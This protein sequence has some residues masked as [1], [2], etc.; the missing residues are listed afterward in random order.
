VEPLD[1]RAENCSCLR[2]AHRRPP[3]RLSHVPLVPA[4]T[5]IGVCHP[6]G[7]LWGSR[8]MDNGF[9]TSHSQ[10][11]HPNPS[12][13][14]EKSCP[15]K[16]QTGWHTATRWGGLAK[17]LRCQRWAH[18]E[19]KLDK[20]SLTYYARRRLRLTVMRQ[21][22]HGAEA[23]QTG[24]RNGRGSARPPVMPVPSVPRGGGWGGGKTS[25][26]IAP[27]VGKYINIFHRRVRLNE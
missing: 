9:E 11:V 1:S 15:R 21:F 25:S 10:T 27:T 24:R 16:K 12:I 26:V 7:A 8:P 14:S 17:T 18:A 13:G 22:A 4:G 20:L 23:H 5:P 19:G 3:L 2:V 6:Y